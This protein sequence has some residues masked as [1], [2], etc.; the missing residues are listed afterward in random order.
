M[1]GILFLVFWFGGATIHTLIELRSQRKEARSMVGTGRGRVKG[2][3]GE[4]GC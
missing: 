1:D 2:S 3:F 4:D